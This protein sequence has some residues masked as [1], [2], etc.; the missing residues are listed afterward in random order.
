MAIKN[1][2]CMN[3]DHKLVCDKQPVLAKFDDENKK[4]IGMDITID[5][6]NDYKEAN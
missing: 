6:C 4:N 2:I 3:C 1:N 5:K